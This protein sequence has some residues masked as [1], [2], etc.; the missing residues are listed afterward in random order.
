M[1]TAGP[2]DQIAW[3]DFTATWETDVKGGLFWLQA[4]LNLPLAPG[5]RVLVS[6]SGAAVQGSPMSGG[7]AGAKRMLW[8]LA[9]YANGVS[10]QKGLGVRF[11][12]IV[13]MQMIAGTGVGMAGAAAY[14]RA[15]GV[16][17]ETVLAR[18]GAPLPPRRFGEH[19]VRILTDP[20]YDAA[21]ALGL[22]GDTGITVLE[23]AA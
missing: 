18:F 23:E 19:V 22:K 15:Q 8:T 13:P 3:E 6:S 2:I 17:P 7:Y 11:Q 1:F 20:Q 5:S 14:A 10:A 16:T 9:K 4:A 12:A 21:L